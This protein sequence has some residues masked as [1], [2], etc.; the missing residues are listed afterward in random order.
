VPH[1]ADVRRWQE[2]AARLYAPGRRSGDIGW[3]GWLLAWW[4]R[5]GMA[6]AILAVLSL[7]VYS[8][9]M[10][11]DGGAASHQMM[12]K[13]IAPAGTVARKEI[14]AA[15]P[16]EMA[17]QADADRQDVRPLLESREQTDA[18][19][20]AMRGVSAGAKS[21]AADPAAPAPKPMALTEP[22]MVVR[23][24]GSP[25]PP[26]APADAL[27]AAA[28]APPAP[29]MARSAKAVA[30]ESI[31]DAQPALAMIAPAKQEAAQG[32]ADYYVSQAG[33]AQ[34]ERMRLAG[35]RLADDSASALPAAVTRQRYGILSTSA[36]PTVIATFEIEVT[37]GRIRVI[38]SDGSVYES[39]PPAPAGA[40]ASGGGVAA[41]RNNTTRRSFGAPPSEAP[42]AM[43]APAQASQAEPP[44]SFQV[45]GTSK[46]LGQAVTFSGS[47][48]PGTGP[49]V[50]NLAVQ[51]QDVKAAAAQNSYRTTQTQ[52]QSPGAG[53]GQ[54][55]L[56]GTLR[57][58]DGP[59][60]PFQAVP[61]EK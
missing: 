7:L 1:P 17:A 33:T 59:A 27:A 15:A 22:N 31:A 38:D 5:F 36:P 55:Q 14:P 51:A 21:V 56:Q 37:D 11:Q 52:A 43:A 12:A 61:L 26:K 41:T 50:T 45:T 4:P 20:M 23:R 10:N 57:V 60:R 49:L 40:S 47:F 19:V 32:L 42:A 18:P 28:A 34:A 48:F 46:R 9:W 24:E 6:G 8:L 30:T 13:N 16:M 58:A 39:A 3:R 29:M 44:A 54:R 25:P 35:T 53:P 2:E